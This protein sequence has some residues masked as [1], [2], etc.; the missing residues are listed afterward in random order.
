MGLLCEIIPGRGILQNIVA[1][2]AAHYRC[3]MMVSQWAAAT[4]PPAYNAIILA[5]PTSSPKLVHSIT[6]F[7]LI[8]PLASRR[9]N[10]PP[11][12]GVRCILKESFFLPCLLAFL[13]CTFLH[14]INRCTTARTC[15][16]GLTRC[17][18]SYVNAIQG[19]HLLHLSSHLQHQRPAMQKM[20]SSSSVTM[21][22]TLMME[23][24]EM[25]VVVMTSR[26]RKHFQGVHLDIL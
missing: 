25:V 12:Q 6:E 9:L 26:Q 24:V 13:F 10:T 1:E 20:V 15:W 19:L 16:N 7:T 22:L 14:M 2:W 17:N 23:K 8:I 4:D 11:L 3:A 5:S 21:M 18:T